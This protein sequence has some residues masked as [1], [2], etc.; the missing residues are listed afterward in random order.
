M[1]HEM[2]AWVNM[3][4]SAYSKSNQDGISKILMYGWWNNV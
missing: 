1:P 4:E 2:S 3:P